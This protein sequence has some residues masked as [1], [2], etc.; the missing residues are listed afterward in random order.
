MVSELLLL[1]PLRDLTGGAPPSAEKAL[2]PGLPLSS[3]EAA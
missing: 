2:Q 1:S 3:A